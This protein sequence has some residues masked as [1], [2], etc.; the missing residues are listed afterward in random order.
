MQRRG[1]SRQQCGDIYA[2][3]DN[4][5]KAVPRMVNLYLFLAFPPRPPL[6]SI[7]LPLPHHITIMHYTVL[8]VH[9]VCF[10]FNSPKSLLLSCLFDCAVCAY[11]T[12][13]AG[14]RAVPKEHKAAYFII[15]QTQKDQS[16]LL[17]FCFFSCFAAL[18]A[19]FPPLP[20]FC[21]FRRLL[22]LWAKMCNSL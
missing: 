5:W 16:S 20:P 10:F 1:R 6:W 22:I 4:W 9:Y 19:V 17:V 12:V 15:T 13:C 14:F 11:V 7:L 2:C 21:T 3:G 18:E 8:Y